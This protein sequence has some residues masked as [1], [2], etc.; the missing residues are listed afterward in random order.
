VVLF[1]TVDATGKTVAA[2][3]QAGKTGWYYVVNRDTGKLIRKSDAFVPQANMFAQPT[4]AGIRMLP[5]ANGGTEWSPVSYDPTLHYAIVSALHQ[6]MIYSTQPQELQSGG[7]WLGSAFAGI[8]T[9][10]QY[11]LLSAIDT[12]TGHLA[13]QYKVDYP[14]IGGSVS[15]A[16]G[17]TFVGESNGNFDAFDTKAG[18]LLW[19]FNTGAGVNAAP[20]VFE[21]DGQEY[22][23]VAS[24]GSFQ[25]GTQYGDSLYVF[26]LP[27]GM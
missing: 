17:V 27:H 9:E 8:P 10:Q 1:D 15:T 23:A 6:P 22:V 24:G 21:Q 18:K 5:G 12:N 25:I 19:Q 26:K 4:K 3:G 16:G 13:W 20:M 11:G 14:M 7:L 2:A